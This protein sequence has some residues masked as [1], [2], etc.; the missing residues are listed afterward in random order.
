L[1]LPKI[2]IAGGFDSRSTMVSTGLG[3]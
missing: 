2:A 3:L 1:R